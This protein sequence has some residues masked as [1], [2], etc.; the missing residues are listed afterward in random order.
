MSLAIGGL[1]TYLKPQIGIPIFSIMFIFGIF[2]IWRAYKKKPIIQKEQISDNYVNKIIIDS[3]APSVLTIPETLKKISNIEAAIT[4]EIMKSHRR[5]KVRMLEKIQ[6]ELRHETGIKP[7]YKFPSMEDV[8]QRGLVLNTIKNLK[9]PAKEYNEEYIRMF[10]ATTWIL[11]KY[12]KGITNDLENNADYCALKKKL[13]E[14]TPK[15]S[16][17]EVGVA[18]STYNN[19]SL[20]LN[21]VV[22]LHSY[23]PHNFKCL[24]PV[25][26]NSINQIKHERDDI[27]NALL[28]NVKNTIE[29]ELRGK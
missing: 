17:A 20:G 3:K 1:S 26:D 15:L 19:T 8:K 11:D 16:Y 22:L 13:G 21:S 2:L 25:L 18:I 9:L 14:E 27:L 23:L 12:G 29:G 10:L 7:N 24:Y 6:K 4:D 28:L 5:V